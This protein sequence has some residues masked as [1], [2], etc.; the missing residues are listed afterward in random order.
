MAAKDQEQ[1]SSED[2]VVL[3]VRKNWQFI[4]LIGFIG[5][6]NAVELMTKQD[7]AQPSGGQLSMAERMISVETKLGFM[8]Q[9]LSEA[10]K[11]LDRILRRQPEPDPMSSTPLGDR[12]ASIENGDVR[13]ALRNLPTPTPGPL[14]VTP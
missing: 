11:K 2:R 5:G 14:R 4:A 10:N 9:G 1:L 3:W 6:P 8:E 13:R 7:N 12:L